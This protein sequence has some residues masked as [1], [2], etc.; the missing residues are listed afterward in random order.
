[1]TSAAAHIVNA[2]VTDLAGM[3]R[4]VE[5]Q[6]T[7]GQDKAAVVMVQFDALKN[8]MRANDCSITTGQAADIGAAIN[9]G[10]WNPEQTKGLHDVVNGLLAASSAQPKR[11][12]MQRLRCFE[13]FK[14]EPEWRSIRNKSIPRQAR[15]AQEANR[16]WSLGVTCPAERE[17]S[18]RVAIII[19]LCEGVGDDGSIQS[20][21][22]E[23]KAAIK[24]CAD[25]RKYPYQHLLDYPTSP[26]DLPE[27]MFEFAYGADRPVVV[28]IPELDAIATRLGCR[29]KAG[30]GPKKGKASARADHMMLEDL[31]ILQ[32][33]AAKRGYE[34]MVRKSGRT[35]Q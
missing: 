30:D 31:K 10:P 27:E 29:N 14:T 25:A 32:T 26:F 20:I 12:G 15:I 35:S 7:G 13:N 3:G 1:M 2:M 9:A 8:R 4:F 33:S 34:I 21:Y 22:E 18:L 28:N 16:L 5:V 24:A 23:L 17:T 19:A 6:V 11:R